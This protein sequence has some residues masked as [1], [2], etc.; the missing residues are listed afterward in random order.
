MR[1]CGGSQTNQNEVLDD[2]CYVTSALKTLRSE[3]HV[4]TIVIKKVIELN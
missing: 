1:R 3:G 4:I 2:C